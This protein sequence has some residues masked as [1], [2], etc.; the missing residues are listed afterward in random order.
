MP[1]KDFSDKKLL[2]TF[3]VWGGGL[4]LLIVLVMCLNSF[5]PSFFIGGN[6]SRNNY[7]VYAGA[8]IDAV[9]A[10]RN[11]VIESKSPYISI[12]VV[13]CKIGYEDEGKITVYEDTNV[14]ASSDK[15]VH[16][17][18]LQI[19]DEE[20]VVWTKIIVAEPKKISKRA[21]VYIN[22]R[23]T[24]ASYS[25]KLDTGASPVTFSAHDEAEEFNI[26]DIFINGTGRVVFPVTPKSSDPFELTIGTM[27]VNTGS[28][29]VDCRSV[30]LGEVSINCTKGSFTFSDIGTET[31]PTSVV[32]KGAYNTFTADNVFGELDF[33]CDSGA[34]TVKKVQ[35][36]LNVVTKSGIIRASQ[37]GGDVDFKASEGSLSVSA[38][39]GDSV[40][41][42][43]TGSITI[44]ANNYGAVGDVTAESVSGSVTVYFA[45]GTGSCDITTRTGSVSVT[46]LTDAVGN[47]KIEGYDGNITVNNLRGNVNISVAVTGKASVVVYLSAVKAGD[48]LLEYKGSTV[49]RGNITL[50]LRTELGFDLRLE[51]T[52]NAKEYLSSSSGVE[53][54]NNGFYYVN[55]GGPEYVVKTSGKFELRKS[56]F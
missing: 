18:F 20:G 15:R 28:V 48:N 10:D 39:A 21:Q 36:D 17:E 40:A 7:I 53:I 47:C 4:I 54:P 38:V 5:L 13:M 16:L 55:E 1:D 32:V 25:F 3:I 2:G 26:Q 33:R 12:E 29:T 41:V 22:L 37:V 44:G 45:A 43:V 56:Y 19:I 31:Q 51:N 34:V 50:Y 14:S 11:L 52:A 23:R 49:G 42:S 24:A 30:I 35:E 27:T 9:F 8:D 6:V 46:Y